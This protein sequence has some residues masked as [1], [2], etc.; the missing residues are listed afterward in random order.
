MEEHVLHLMA[1]L[2]G[3]DALKY[4]IETLEVDTGRLI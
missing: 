3:V 4:A 1:N 2:P